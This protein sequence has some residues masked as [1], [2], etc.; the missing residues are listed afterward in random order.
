M[1][2]G[3]TYDLRS[4]YLAAGYG[5]EETAEFDQESTITAIDDAIRTM[6]HETVR[7]GH[8]RD[9][10]A[11]LAAG[12]RW[13][14]VFNI[15]E[16]LRGVGRESQVP[17]LLEAYGI[18]STFS[19]ASV[20][21]LCLNKAWTK[22]VVGHAVPTAAFHV[23]ESIA[24]VAQVNLPLPLFVKPLAEGTG[25]GV[26]A[27]S[28]IR[29]RADLHDQCERLLDTFRQPA[30]VE[31]YLPGREFTVSILGTGNDSYVLGTFEIIL[32]SDAEPEV[33]SY[34]NKEEWE[35][36]VK[37]LVADANSDPIVAQAQAHALAA[38]RI[39]GC[40]DAGRIDMR[41]DTHGMPHF[42]EVNP[43]AG[44]NPT[45]SDLPM[46]AIAIGLSYPELIERIVTS[47]SKRIVLA[48]EK[49]V[50]KTDCKVA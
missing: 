26:T 38:W 2:V 25:K 36:R 22:A 43:L 21:A 6:G 47:A 37:Y 9:L 17:C 29:H 16:G 31:T 45:H 23:V 8:V 46:L 28:V 5:E 42:I 41:C 15:C 32:L 19:D 40:R 27:G 44:L 34:V 4:A 49:P 30:L 11:R 12:E 13:D 20:L 18:P 48:G 14:L 39:L 50:S 3:I 24:D 35:E 7:I 1:L 33:Y 10:V